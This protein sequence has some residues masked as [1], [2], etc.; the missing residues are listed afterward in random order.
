MASVTIKAPAKKV[1]DTLTKP[2]LR[3]K[4][5]FG[6]DTETDWK[7]G[8]PIIHRGEFQGKPYQD[9][10]VVKQFEP[11][12]R[13]VHTHWSAMSGR[14]DK[15]ENYETVT[16]SLTEKNGATE[17]DVAEVNVA[18]DEQRATSEKMWKQAL[19]ELKKVAEG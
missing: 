3:K 15:P 14:P 1:W 11:E 12:K 10:G 18:S 17:V 9:K 6:V 19:A 5:F 2:S 8:S 4:W 13:I 7:V 16:Y